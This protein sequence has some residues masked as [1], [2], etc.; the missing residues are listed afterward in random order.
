MVPHDTEQLAFMS[1]VFGLFEDF[2]CTDLVSTLPATTLSVQR[3]V[4]VV[5]IR[6]LQKA[7]ANNSKNHRAKLFAKASGQQTMERASDM[8]QERRRRP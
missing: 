4:S 5:S 3:L 7:K 8:L 1:G 6:T 2:L